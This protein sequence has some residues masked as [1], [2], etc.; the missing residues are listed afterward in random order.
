MSLQRKRIIFYS[1]FSLMLAVISVCSLAYYQLRNLGEIKTHAIKKLEELTRREVKIGDA[2]MDIVRGLSI[3]LKDVSLKSRI[4][5]EPE[6]EA[7]SV[8]VVVKLLPL[9]NKRVEVKKII[10]QGVSLN[11]VRDAEGRLSVGNVKKWITQPSESGLFKV[12]RVSLMN[13][14]MVEDGTIHFQDYLNRPPDDPL[15]LNLRHIHFSV[16]K[17]LLNSPFQFNVKGE[18][19]GD[20]TPTGFQVS[21]AFDNFSK[22]QGI[23][24]ISINGKVRVDELNVSSFQPYLKKVLA[25]APL[26][27]ML[28][29][30]SSFSGNL[31]GAL[32]TEG[33]LK[34][35]TD[36]N[37]GHAILRDA[38]VPHR[39]GLE[40]KIALDQDSL[41]IEELKSESGPFKFRA[42]ASLAN[43]LSKD[44]SISLDLVSDSFQVN[45]SMDYLPLKFFPEEYHALVQSRFKNGSIKINALKFDGTLEQLQELAQEKNRGLIS[46]EFEMKHVDW[47]APL[48]ALQNVSGTFSISKGKTNLHIAKAKYEN[49]PITNVHGTITDIMTRPSVDLNLENEVDIRQFHGTLKKVF[50]GHPLFDSIAVYDEFEGTANVRLDVKGP[51][52]DFDKLAISGKIGLQD[53]SLNDEEFE[54]RLENLNG[55]IIYTHTPEADKRKDASWIPVLRYDNLSGN[56]SKSSFSGMNG[57]MGFSNG[58]PLEKMTTTYKIASSDLPF[59]LSDNSEDAL[60]NLKEGLDFTAGQVV[61]DYRFQR[62]PTLPETKKEWGEIELKNVSMKYPDRLH[63]MN[64]LNGNI[65]YGGGKI[66]LENLNGR[67]GDSPVQLEG[68]IDRK[69]I[70]TLEYALRLNFPGLAQSDLKDIPLFEDLKFSGPAHVSLNLNGNLDSFVFEHQADLARVGYEIPGFMEKRP[71]ALSKFKAK[72]SV[73][74]NKGLTIDNW[75]YEL[76]GNQVSGTVR[77]PDLDNPEFTISM[78]ANDFQAYPS[79]QFFRFISAEIDGS[80]DF[81][82]VG[83]GNLNDLQ[84]AKFEGEMKLNKLKIRP[85]NFLSSVTVDA[86]LKFKEN[87]LDIRSGNI[88]SDQSGLNFSG[89]Y[90]RGDSPRLELNLSGKGLNIDEIFP[91]PQGEDISLI[92]RLNQS[93][94][95]SR[96]KGQ[97]R[98]NLDRL[99]YKHLNLDRVAGS[100][101]LRER[102]LEMKDITFASNASV[103]SGG[104]MFIDLEGVGHFE[105][106]VQAR[107]METKN[108]FGFFG[109]LFGDSLSGNVKMIDARMSGS[110]KDWREISQ[111]LSG[112]ISLN[113]QSGKINTARLKKGVHRLFSSI[114]Q[115]ESLEEDEASPYRQ[116]SGDFSC[117]EGVFE[118]ENFVIE[119]ENRRTSVVGNFDLVN[120]QMDTV[121]GVAPMAQLDRFLTKIPLVGKIITGGD[122]KSLVKSYYTVKGDFNDPDVSAIP[123]T[124]L[125][126]KLMGIFQGIFQT[127]QDILSPITDNLKTAPPPTPVED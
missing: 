92:E 42:K 51:L 89:V 43:F 111:S 116:I 67:Y 70:K 31:G 108:L 100:I 38:R 110:G 47:Q 50:K 71:N 86:N 99:V 79:R 63:A 121:V 32:K 29:L 124:S 23:T 122:E 9:L 39:G 125:G 16:R 62:D 8:W 54:P 58:Q 18:I 13:Q 5:K 112:N 117:K 45:K 75:T 61:M 94:F 114:P 46:S 98:F 22:D 81:K 44:P 7:S 84:S 91:E 37:K 123:F 12:L 120:D 106:N 21:G 127:P 26:D 97:V 107:E 93:D 78:Q 20:G 68:E 53:V 56:F 49:Q 59:I 15:P 90:F 66:R 103:K 74:K 41:H 52:D 35:S 113:I 33:T 69:N 72:G 24:G 48:P 60:V 83:S 3:L 115:P 96:G 17:S 77:I 28:S 118:T 19:P 105:G 76:G 10:V 82:I 27:S 11:V 80:T 57:E 87:R 65:S 25:K 73:E 55:N 85:E 2:E 6:L 102:E 34:Y 36:S 101:L 109:D 1:L 104:K 30:K 4:A 40:Y 64:N 14:L 88:V 119:T 126:K 95:F